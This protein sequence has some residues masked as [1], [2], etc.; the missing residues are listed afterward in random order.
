MFTCRGKTPSPLP[1][2]KYFIT[3]ELQVLAKI[4]S[5]M[6]G[7]RLLGGLW[8]LLPL[9]SSLNGF[10]VSILIFKHTWPDWPR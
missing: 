5:K 6:L 8:D 2:H 3:T 4:L 1:V 9:P 10:H 7:M